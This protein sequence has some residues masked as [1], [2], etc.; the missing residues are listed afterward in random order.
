MEVPVNNKTK[1]L[2]SRHSLLDLINKNSTNESNT[3]KGQET[4][5]KQEKTDDKEVS[6][7][8]MCSPL[9]RCY[10]LLVMKTVANLALQMEKE[11]RVAISHQ[12]R[13]SRRRKVQTVVE[14][15]RT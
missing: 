1:G 9:N 7:G 3:K 13:G 4:I 6:D 15:N 14:R 5:I 10:R 8:I 2:Q 12:R 11:R